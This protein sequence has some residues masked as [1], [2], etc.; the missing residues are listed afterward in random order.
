MKSFGI[1]AAAALLLNGASAHYIWNQLDIDGA[2]GSGADGIRPN[3]NYNSPVTGGFPFIP[4]YL[5]LPLLYAERLTVLQTSR[6]TTC[7]ATRAASPAPA[8]R[9]GTS[10]PAA[11][12]PFTPTW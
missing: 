9:S 6:P 5:L 11:S 2:A 4:L 7:A 1:T 12:L 8:P 3:T 10:R